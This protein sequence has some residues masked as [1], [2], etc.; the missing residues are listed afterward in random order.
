MCFRQV[1]ESQTIES[2]ANEALNTSNE[3]YRIAQE[4]VQKPGGISS[5]IDIIRRRWDITYLVH[6]VVHEQALVLL[7]VAYGAYC[8]GY[9]WN[10]I[11]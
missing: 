9:V 5:E 1:A 8:R 2:T 6:L 7:F 3:A 4:A 10:K 11:I